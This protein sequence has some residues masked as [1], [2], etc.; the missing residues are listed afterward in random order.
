[1]IN[2]DVLQPL[3]STKHVEN[4]SQLPETPCRV[5]CTSLLAWRGKGPAYR[6]VALAQRN[7]GGCNA[8]TRARQTNQQEDGGNV[9]WN[10]ARV[11]LLAKVE[12]GRRISR[13]AI[14]FNRGQ[15]I[16]EDLMAF[17]RGLMMVEPRFYFGLT[18][19]ASDQGINSATRVLE[20]EGRRSVER[21]KLMWRDK[22]EVETFKI[23]RLKKETW[24]LFSLFAYLCRLLL[25]FSALLTLRTWRKNEQMIR[26][27]RGNQ[28]WII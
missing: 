26:I 8:R 19:S 12:I 16:L 11:C 7:C 4:V 20:L 10:W 9:W 25:Q 21:E 27:Y 15:D 3:C 2:A 28:V 1:M 14:S 23:E 18:E 6:Y 13:A 5:N 24:R 22:W 17:A